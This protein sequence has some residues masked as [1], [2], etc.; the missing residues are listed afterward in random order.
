MYEA[1]Y[2]VT[3]HNRLETIFMFPSF[4]THSEFAERMSLPRS[5]VLSAGFVAIGVDVNGE[6]S[7]STYGESISLDKK[8]RPEDKRLAE[9]MFR[10]NC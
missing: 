8:S 5:A 3:Y 1:K 6:P 4:V 10:V 2:I 7:I 9:M